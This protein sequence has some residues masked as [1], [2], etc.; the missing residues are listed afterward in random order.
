MDRIDNSLKGKLRPGSFSSKG[1]RKT[2]PSRI[3]G[4]EQSRT[5][6]FN[7]E[8]TEAVPITNDTELQEVVNSIHRLGDRLL[9]YPHPDTVAHY[10]QAVRNF[11]NHVTGNAYTTREYISR[12]DILNQKKYVL[13]QT[14]DEKLDT[15]SRNVLGSQKNQLDLLSTIEEIQ[16]LLVNL[17]HV[18]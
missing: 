17:I 3:S 5:G 8:E 16:G 7:V 4:S 14:I 15:L 11:I 12:R 6:L 2:A 9:K 1:K 10:R 13:I 18:S